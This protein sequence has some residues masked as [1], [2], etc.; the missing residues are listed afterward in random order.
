MTRTS[1]SPG[2]SKPKPSTRPPAASA[3]DAIGRDVADHIYPFPRHPD[4]RRRRASS[5]PERTA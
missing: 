4:A 1:A 2:A 5:S 3:F